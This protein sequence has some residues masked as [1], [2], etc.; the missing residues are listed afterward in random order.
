MD[1]HDASA[2]LVAFKARHRDNNAARGLEDRGPLRLNARTALR[3]LVSLL[4]PLRGRALRS[5]NALSTAP[6]RK[7]IGYRWDAIRFSH[8][9]Y[10]VFHAAETLSADAI[11]WIDA[12]TFCFRDIPRDFIEST[13]PSAAML[14][15]LGRRYRTSECGYVGYNL[16]HPRIHNF[17]SSW[18]ELYDTDALFELEEWHDSWVFDWLRKRFER[19]GVI[20]HDLSQGLGRR[21]VNHPFVNGPLGAYMDHLKG[22]RKQH[23][24]S[25]ASDLL[26][27]RKESYWRESSD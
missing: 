10:C 2:G 12:D 14:S 1:L 9:T 19:Q 21:A 7:G 27:S 11:F 8:K 18:R 16:R 23:G 3:N 17:L 25:L 4:E 5:G 20:T 26:V 15:F 13:L 22:E 24:R 6:K